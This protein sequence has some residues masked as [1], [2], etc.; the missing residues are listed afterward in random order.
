MSSLNWVQAL[1]SAQVAGGPIS[2][3]VSAASLIPAQAKF[4]IPAGILKIGD[5]FRVTSTYQVSNVVTTPGTLTLDI[6]FGS[7]IVFTSGAVQMSTTAHTTLPAWWSALMTVRALG[8]TTAA[9]LMGQSKLHGIMFLISGADL[10]THGTML[11][12]NVTP[13]VG[14]GFDSTIS[15]A[16]DHFGTFSVATSPTNITLQQY[17]FEFLT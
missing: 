12:P 4:T 7:I 17:V 15:N 8:L 13:V 5:V 1:A 14:T 16:V 10:T 9:N 2:N 6:R 3:S 11:A